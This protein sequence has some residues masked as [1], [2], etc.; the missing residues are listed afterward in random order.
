MQKWKKDRLQ[1][2]F[3]ILK[4]SLFNYQMAVRK[5]KSDFF[6]HLITDNTKRPKVLFDTIDSLLNPTMNTLSEASA[7]LC[8]DF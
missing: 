7:E 8:E 6:S 2:S 5:A 3:D 4:S 1:V